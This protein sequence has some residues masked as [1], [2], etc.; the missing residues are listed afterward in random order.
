[1][2]KYALIVGGNGNLGKSVVNSFIYSKNLIWEVFNIDLTEN[3]YATQNILLKK[4]FVEDD[5][6]LLKIYEEI[7]G[8]K[9]NSV[10]CVAGGWEGGNL[11]DQK[12]L[13]SINKMYLMNLYSSV[14]AVNIAQKYLLSNSL[15]VLTSAA[16]V[17]KQSNTLGSISYQLSKQSVNNLTDTLIQYPDLLPLKTK[18]VTL[19]PSIIDTESNRKNI[20][21]DRSNW[22]NPDKIAN[23]LKNWSDDINDAPKETYYFL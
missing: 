16:A 17:K 13:C 19:C 8:I 15:L 14:I 5:N 2:R 23:L 7:G 21:G 12:I 18:I 6:S 9:F 20:P 10:I 3:K 1:M 22:V 4:N 11:N